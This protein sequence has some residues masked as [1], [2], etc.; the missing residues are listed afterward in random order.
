MKKEELR[1]IIEEHLL[2]RKRLENLREELKKVEDRYEEVGE[3]LYGFRSKE[4]LRLVLS[5]L[6][7]LR[8]EYGKDQYFD[9][10]VE[11]VIHCLEN[12]K[13]IEERKNFMPRHLLHIY[14]EKIE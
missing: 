2:L 9:D 11:S 14:D 3:L 1:G 13:H 10:L 4:F 8:G 7:D 5:Y 6:L 12:H